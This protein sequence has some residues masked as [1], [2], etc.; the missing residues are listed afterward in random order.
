MSNPYNA[1]MHPGYVGQAFSQGFE[2]AN[3]RLQ[4]NERR[5]A[6]ADYYSA[7]YGG[8]N[9]GAGGGIVATPEQQ[10]ETAAMEARF[11]NAPQTNEGWSGPSNDV[12]TPELRRLL[13]VSP[14]VAVPILQQRQQAQAEAR[15]ADI[16]RRAAQ[17]DPQ[18]MAE[19]A[20]FDL[21]AFRG[22]R[23]DEREDIETRVG[24]LGQ[25]AL[26][27]SNMPPEQRAAAWD[28]S[29]QQLSQR[30]PELAQY[31]GQYSEQALNGVLQQAELVQ[32][33]IQNARPSY[34][35][36][37]Q[38]GT[39]VDTRNPQAVA[40][41]SGAPQQGA[42][43]QGQPSTI[44]AADFSRILQGFDGDAARA[45]RYTQESDVA[46]Q[47]NSA[48]EADMLPPGTRIILNG[49]TGTVQ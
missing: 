32:T 31:A 10:A 33:A 49:R 6:L 12:M 37:P 3:Q 36:I 28:A 27:I 2:M 47:I 14:D 18:A 22:L 24:A 25:A 19:M 38:G 11:P 41:V 30:W 23:S 8:S 4:E 43:R 15:E 29:V 44:T 39:L 45:A 16:R 26:Q 42:P 21:D 40:S 34:M 13:E 7:T 17:G 46:V 20:G 9:T 1:L 5:N 35:A 48:A